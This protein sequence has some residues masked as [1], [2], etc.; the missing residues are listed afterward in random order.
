MSIRYIF[1]SVNVDGP[2]VYAVFDKKISHSAFSR[3]WD[4][5]FSAE[6]QQPQY[7]EKGCKEFYE[8]IV[9]SNNRGFQ[10]PHGAFDA[11]QFAAGFE[12]IRRKKSELRIP[13]D[14]DYLR[15]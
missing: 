14:C 2:H 4:K 3:V 8:H 11:D 5:V 10:L 13:F 15:T 1:R 7:D 9:E 12:A 6:H